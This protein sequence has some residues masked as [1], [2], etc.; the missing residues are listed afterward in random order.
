MVWCCY[1]DPTRGGYFLTRFMSTFSRLAERWWEYVEHE[2][3]VDENIG[4]N[5]NKANNRLHVYLRDC[6]HL[7]EN[8]N[9]VHNTT[10]RH[11]QST[12][13]ILEYFGKWSGS[14]CNNGNGYKPSGYNCRIYNILVNRLYYIYSARHILAMDEM[15]SGIKGKFYKNLA[16]LV[17]IS[18]RGWCCA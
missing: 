8:V 6:E 11:L 17:T 5:H 1:S 15:W 12:R 3:T 4:E 16:S 9:D 7:G 2:E 14:F 18:E 10:R 13:S